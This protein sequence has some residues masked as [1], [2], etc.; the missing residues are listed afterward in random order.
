MDQAMY[1]EGDM[2]AWD[3]VEGYQLL[4]EPVSRCKKKRWSYPQ[5]V[6]IP[7]HPCPEGCAE[8]MDIKHWTGR[9]CISC[10]PGLILREGRCHTQELILAGNWT[11]SNSTDLKSNFKFLEDKAIE[12]KYSF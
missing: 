11:V 8:C 5:P 2:I 9:D 10:V 7:F 6:C 1:L 3:C 12:F 4:G